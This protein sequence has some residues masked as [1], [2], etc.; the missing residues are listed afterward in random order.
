MPPTYTITIQKTDDD[1]P[2]SCYICSMRTVEESL[3]ACQVGLGSSISVAVDDWRHQVTKWLV[4]HHGFSTW[5][6]PLTFTDMSEIR[7]LVMNFS[8]THV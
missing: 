3:L 6:T 2:I 1:S 8:W 4:H 7:N 5:P